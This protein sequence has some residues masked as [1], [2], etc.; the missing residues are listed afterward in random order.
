MPKDTH[1][2]SF[3][4]Y[5]DDFISDSAVDAMSNDELGMYVRLL[6]KAWKELPAGTVPSDER[7]LASWAK[8]TPQAWKRGREGVLRAFAIGDDGRLHQKRMA[9]EWEKM[10]ERR[11]ASS[12]GGK[13]STDNRYG[14]STGESLVSDDP[15]DSVSEGMTKSNLSSSSSLSS[16]FSLDDDDDGAIDF[17]CLRGDA[18]VRA[19]RIVRLS[20]VDVGKPDNFELVAKV[21]ILWGQGEFADDDIEQVLESYG[22]TTQKITNRGAWLHAC[23]DNRCRDV[24][25]RSFAALLARTQIPREVPT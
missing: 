19:R 13:K 18:C 9:L 2:P 3:P 14:K 1:P 10:E 17:S 11:Q 24:L 23:F 5:V 4:F 21:A 25:R 6:C 12:R 15:S 8:A 7:I 20:K 16:S 22:A